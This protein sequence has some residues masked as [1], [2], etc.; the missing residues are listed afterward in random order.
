MQ[1]GIIFQLNIHIRVVR[2]I[3]GN[4]TYNSKQDQT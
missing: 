3:A 4:N 2:L 1:D